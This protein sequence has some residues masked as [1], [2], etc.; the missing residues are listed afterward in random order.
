MTGGTAFSSIRALYSS[1]QEQTKLEDSQEL[2]PATT[3]PCLPIS[4]RSILSMMSQNSPAGCLQYLSAFLENVLQGQIGG[5]R[6]RK[7]KKRK[8]WFNTSERHSPE[9]IQ[10]ALRQL[11]YTDTHQNAYTES[12]PFPPQRA[13]KQS[14]PF[15]SVEEW[16]KPFSFSWPSVS[17][18]LTQACIVLFSAAMMVH[19]CRIFSSRRLPSPDDCVKGTGSSQ[20]NSR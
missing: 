15:P 12:F 6:R 10:P 9:K 1:V 14:I 7:K 19:C 8:A 17:C 5:V 4:T 20:H 3:V 11:D 13:S 2:H 18:H 16:V